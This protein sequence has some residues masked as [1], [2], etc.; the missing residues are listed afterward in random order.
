MNLQFIFT[1][2]K[3]IIMKKLLLIIATVVSAFNINAQTNFITAW[4]S[5]AAVT[6]IQI[7]AL[8][9][10]GAVNYTWTALPSGNTGSSNFTSTIASSVALT[11][12]APAN[13]TITIEMQ[14]TNLKQFYMFFSPDATKLIDVKQWGSSNW[15]SMKQ[16]FYGCTKLQVTAT[17]IPD[18]SNV[19][20]M[21]SMFYNCNILSGPNNINS[22]NV[23]NVTVMDELFSNATV[24]NQPLN[25]WNVSNVQSMSSMFANTGAFNQ[26]I[27]NWNTNN[28]NSMSNMFEGATAFN[29]PIGTWSI[30]NVNAISGMFYYATSFNQSLNS[31]NTTNVYD[32]SAVFAYC[33]AFN[34]PLNNWNTGN[35]TAMN[36]MFLSATSF[37]QDIS[38]WNTS[39]VT[40]MFG[41]F[42]QATNFNQPL[43]NWNIS[44]V[45]NLQAMFNDAKNFN[46]PL[47]SWNTSNVTTFGGLFMGATNFNQPLNN[48]N[49]SNVTD[50]GSCFYNASFL[51]GTFNQDIGN[52]DLSSVLYMSSFFENSGIDCNNYSSTLIG[53]NSNTLTPNNI[54]I[55]NIAGVNYGTN[56][57]AARNNLTAVKGWT[58][59][60]DIAGSNACLGTTTGINELNKTV[61]SVFPNP[62]NSFI[63]INS[64]NTL[65]AVKI[66]NLLGA[67]VLTLETEETTSKIDVSNLTSGVYFIKV[68]NSITKFIKE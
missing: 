46:Q 63:T 7:K 60:G 53:W 14:P 68:K 48:W 13:N 25:N 51:P 58:I 22:W 19:F 35:V 54:N 27:G 39:N 20:N 55:G 3:K 32:M 28:V 43:N 11:V 8:T 31:W 66:T 38:T 29:Q 18:L 4:T 44:N 5:T 56:A 41:M 64:D 17:D 30:T 21:S 6:S 36:N 24:F 2:N 34:Q 9:Q 65:G 50:M 62:T 67:E 10:G 45:T 57:V 12:N 16:M 47:N 26:P 40:T 49:T 42:R 37:N 61:L 52:W 23:S 33:P 59:T 15:S 1:E